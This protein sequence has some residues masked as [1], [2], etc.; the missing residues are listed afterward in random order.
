MPVKCE[1]MNRLLCERE[2]GITGPLL[3]RRAETARRTFNLELSK[4]RD[5]EEVHKGSVNSLDLDIAENR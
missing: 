4:Y 5:V 2:I 1:I 3:L